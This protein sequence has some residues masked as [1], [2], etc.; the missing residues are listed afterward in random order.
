MVEVR[1]TAFFGGDGNDS[2][3]GGDGDDD[4]IGGLGKDIFTCG[5]GND[6][7]HDF[8]ELEGDSVNDD[9]ETIIS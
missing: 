3:Y 7:V 5:K 4:L 1:M 9:C 8:I 2:L 6:V